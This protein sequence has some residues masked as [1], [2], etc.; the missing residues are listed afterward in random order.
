MDTPF[1]NAWQRIVAHAGKPFVTDT[2]HEFHYTVEDDG[3]LLLSS[4]KTTVPQDLL[5]Q[6][7][8]AM[9]CG[10][11]RQL[12]RQ[13]KP[14]NFLWAILHDTRILGMVPEAENKRR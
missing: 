3:S 6:V 8:E 9:P 7:W 5:G 11:Y 14:R 4:W 2:G 1:E 13:C 12:P 10:D